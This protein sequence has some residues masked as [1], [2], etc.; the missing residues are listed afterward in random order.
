MTTAVKPVTVRNRILSL[1][2]LRGFALFGILLM[3]IQ[4]FAMPEAAYSIPAVFGDLTGANLG[5]WWFSY[6]FADQKFMTL[7]S[8]LFG[9]GIVLMTSKAERQG[10]H[11]LRLH[12]RR[13]FWLLII[14]L[15][16][17]YLLW[18]GDVLVL[19]A[20]CGFVI[21][22]FRRWSPKWL[23][24]LGVIVFAV[25]PLLSFAGGASVQYA[26]SE[27]RAELVADFWPSQEVLDTE[28][29][30]YRSGWLGQMAARVPMAV[31]LQTTA[32]FF[33]GFWRAGGLMLMGMAFFKWGIFSGERRNRF[34]LVLI[35][36]GLLIGLPVVAWGGYQN[37][38]HGWDPIYA[39]LG[40]GY[41]FNY[42]ASL[43]VSLGYVGMI[44]LWLRT[45]WF[46]MV[47][48]RVGIGGAD[49]V[50]QLLAPDDHCHIYL[51]RSRLWAF[52]HGLSDPSR[53]SSCSESG[54]LSW[55]SRRSGYAISA[56]VR[57]SGCGAR[58]PTGSF[59]R[60][61]LPLPRTRPHSS[62]SDREDSRAERL[63]GLGK[64]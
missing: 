61:A 35:A 58:S 24:L 12:Y 13:M 48:A 51:L 23:L 1:D 40:M 31:E 4:F 41:Q 34:Y 59:S 49:G 8:M 28:I 22:W 32:L 36:M 39:R 19:Y 37:F 6:L 17:G 11:S 30:A 14:G 52:C 57:S 56:S 47:A 16:H 2:V 54:H 60:C 43:F 3:N 44:V 46:A 53:C 64:E 9:A 10:G 50:D 27:V 21:Y 7:F 29:E 15:V 63:T 55:F 38:A 26:P 33:W 62:K 25:G 20:I 5:V 18:S 45:G 42:W